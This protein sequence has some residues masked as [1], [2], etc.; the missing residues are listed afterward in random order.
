MAFNPSG[1][2]TGKELVTKLESRI[3]EL[4]AENKAL[5]RQIQDGRSGADARE[6]YLV[7]LQ[8]RSRQRRQNKQKL[9]SAFYWVR[10][11]QYIVALIAIIIGLYVGVPNMASQSIFD[12]FP[13]EFRY[14]FVWKINDKWCSLL[15]G[16]L[17]FLISIPAQRTFPA[18]IRVF[19]GTVVFGIKQ[20]LDIFLPNYFIILLP[21]FGLFVLYL[22]NEDRVRQVSNQSRIIESKLSQSVTFS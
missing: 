6:R 5:Q 22:L 16:F 8:Y 19:Y 12:R 20:I 18:P 17:G 21:L 10:I 15:T 7:E 1:Q 3:K 4:Q 14:Y 2:K 13:K 9:I 11:S